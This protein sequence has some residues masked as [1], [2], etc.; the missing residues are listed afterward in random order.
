MIEVD[1]LHGTR[2]VLGN[3]LPDPRSPIS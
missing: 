2:K 3:Q 1:N